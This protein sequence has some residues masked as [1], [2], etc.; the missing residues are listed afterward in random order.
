MSKTKPKSIP[1]SPSELS[2]LSRGGLSMVVRRVEPQPRY[3]MFQV[4]GDASENWYNENP[5]YPRRGNMMSMTWRCPL[6]SVGDVLAVKERW[7]AWSELDSLPFDQFHKFCDD[8]KSHINFPD[9]GNVWKSK[10]RPARTMPVE[11][12][13]F[14]L[15]LLSVEVRRV[16]EITEDEARA[17]GISVL[18]LQDAN[19]TSAWWQSSPGK[20]QARTARDSFRMFWND[21]HGVGA[22]AKDWGWFVKCEVVK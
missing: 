19:D 6:G 2:A 4:Q 3:K 11:V 14:S 12:A 20:H 13:R 21:R 10:I 9:D 18:P 1:L 22:F 7:Q 5:D 8:P 17:C 16:S 15:K